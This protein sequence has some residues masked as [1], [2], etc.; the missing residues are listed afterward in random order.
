MRFPV[1]RLQQKCCG[2]RNKAATPLSSAAEP[3]RNAQHAQ[4][5]PN[6]RS[7]IAQHA[8]GDANSTGVCATRSCF[9]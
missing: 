3:G 5:L 8:Q 1:S 9:S 2:S 4:W 6:M 7:G